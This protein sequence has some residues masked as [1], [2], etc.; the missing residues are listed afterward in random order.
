VNCGTEPD[1]QARLDFTGTMKMKN[2]GIVL[3]FVISAPLFAAEPTKSLLYIGAYGGRDGSKGISVCDFDSATGKLS[4]LRLAV[5]AR[6]PSF[7]AFHPDKSTLFAVGE[8][9]NSE[10]KPGG[11][12]SGYKIDASSGKLTL[13]NSQST[14]GAGPCHLCVDP[15]GKAVLVANYGGGSVASFPIKDGSTLGETASFIQHQGSSAN[16]NRQKAPH[17]H[18]INLDKAAKFAFCADLGVDKV[19]V[20]KFD[21]ATAKLTPND[22]PSVSVAPGSGPRHFAFHPSGKLAYVINELKFTMTAFK[23]DTDKG[24][25]TE[26]QTISTLPAGWE[27]QGGTAEVV[28]HPNGKFLYGSNRGHDSIAVLNI[29]EQTGKMTFLGTQG[30]GVKWPRNFVLDPTGKWLLVGNEQGASITVYE[31][32]PETGELHPTENRIETPKPACLRFLVR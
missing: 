1:S 26:I 14:V 29:D 20:Y 4:N 13:I 31:V 15:E 12:V 8:T 32:D 25:L 11:S 10:G 9:A 19:F 27:G 7:L 17:A 21:A 5:E 2:F 24:T 28:V 30:Q 6:N 16:P 23:Y 18:S 22:P 3:T